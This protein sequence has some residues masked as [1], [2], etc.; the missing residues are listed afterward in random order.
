MQYSQY[1][2]LSF[3]E[4]YFKLNGRINRIEFFLFY[5]VL[6]LTFSVGGFVISGLSD[7]L[8]EAVGQDNIVLV[9]IFE[10]TYFVVSSIVIVWSS[11]AL[12]VKRCHDFGRSST[13]GLLI[14]VPGI[15]V[16][17]LAAL[18]YFKGSAGE[19]QFGRTPLYVP[20]REACPECGVPYQNSEKITQ[21]L[22]CST[23][24]KK[25]LAESAEGKVVS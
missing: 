14:L 23:C 2:D 9:E 15:N 17:F 3:I 22:V 25:R 8:M 24:W 16:F 5:V 11:I 12:S 20:F 4:I 21:P 19:N 13:L 1:S 10:K 18:L 6:V 7:T